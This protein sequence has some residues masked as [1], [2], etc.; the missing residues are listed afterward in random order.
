[1]NV[2]ELLFSMQDESYRDFHSRL[3]PTVDK[4]KIIG[5]RAPM[6]RKTA[7]AMTDTQADKFMKSL[8]H[9]YYEENNLHAFLI[10]NIK[11]FDLCIRELDRFLPY[12]DNWATCDGMNPKVLGKR[13][14]ELM[15]KILRW[16][17]SGH[18]YTVRFAVKCLMDFYLDAN[19]STDILQLVADVKSE[20]YYV[21]MMCAWFFATA[22]CK[23][24]D[25]T[26]PFFSEKK[27]DKRV[28]N[29]AISK[30]CE[31][32]RVDAEIKERLRGLR[33]K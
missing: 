14:D 27:L 32:L 8:P 19:F 26:L 33:I 25:S 20:E 13:P 10:A 16:L 28:H 4:E 31:S 22:L 29:K 3:M 9:K 18:T 12:V 24:P 2:T 7:K 17:H 5:V 1:M 30:A 6:L 11:D 21:K 15:N 23:Q